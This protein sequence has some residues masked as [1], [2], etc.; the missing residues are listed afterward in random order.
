MSVSPTLAILLIHHTNKAG[1]D[2]RGA[3]SIRDSCDVL[4]HLGREDGD[5]DRE[6]DARDERRRSASNRF[7]VQR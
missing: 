1:K 7:V 6:T 4:W 5:D 3:S 2:F